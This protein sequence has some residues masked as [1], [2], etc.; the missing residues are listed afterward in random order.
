M[1]LSGFPFGPWW[2]APEFIG[3]WEGCGC[4]TGRSFHCGRG[5]YNVIRF[6]WV[7]STRLGWSFHSFLANHLGFCG[8]NFGFFQKFLGE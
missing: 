6:E 5:F 3:N 1:C 7:Q 2:L 4:Q 8:G